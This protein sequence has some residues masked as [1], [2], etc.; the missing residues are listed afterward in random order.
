MDIMKHAIDSSEVT[1][2]DS[3]L[4]ILFSHTYFT[5]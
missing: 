1:Y 4:K 2:N 3:T 5:K